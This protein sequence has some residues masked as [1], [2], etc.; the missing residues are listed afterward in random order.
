MFDW[1]LNTSCLF[2][3][4]ETLIFVRNLNTPL[5][6]FIENCTDKNKDYLKD[7]ILVFMSYLRHGTKILEELQNLSWFTQKRII[8]IRYGGKHNHDN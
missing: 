3:S 4:I 8:L 2:Y 6:L 1:V 7:T 5:L